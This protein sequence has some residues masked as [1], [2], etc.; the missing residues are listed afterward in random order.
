[1]PD[2]DP[3]ELPAIQEEAFLE[4]TFEE[5][6][7]LTGRGPTVGQLQHIFNHPAFRYFMAR[8]K[9]QANGNA[10][11]FF[12]GIAIPVGLQATSPREAYFTALVNCGRGVI[13]MQRELWDEAKSKEGEA[14]EETPVPAS[15]PEEN[16]F[17]EGVLTT[18][19]T[20]Q[21]E[22]GA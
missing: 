22:H 16:P 17:G 10:N 21:G 13:N 4:L 6:R 14:E 12:S 9:K 2:F 7:M 20:P 19:A 18:F 3:S 5:R 1:M 11:Q 15:N 8:V